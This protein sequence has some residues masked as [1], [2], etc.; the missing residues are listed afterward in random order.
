MASM[1]STTQRTPFG[2]SIPK[3]LILRAEKTP[4]QL[5]QRTITATSEKV[6]MLKPSGTPLETSALRAKNSDEQFGQISSSCIGAEC[7]S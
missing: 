6:K 5:G 3:N 2:E 7:P 1:A 4:W